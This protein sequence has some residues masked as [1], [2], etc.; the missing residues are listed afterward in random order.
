MATIKPTQSN[1]TAGELDPKTYARIDYEGYLKGC[2]KLRNFINIPQGGF[3]TRWGQVYVDTCTAT[4]YTQVQIDELIYND[5]AIYLLLWEPDTLTIYLENHVVQVLNNT[6]YLA[7]DVVNIYPTQ[8]TN[9]LVTVDA[10]HRPKLLVRSSNATNNITGFNATNNTLEITAAYPNSDV[11]YPVRFQNL[12]LADS[13]PTTSPQ[14]YR[15]REYF[16]RRTTGDNI[17]IY[18]TASDANDGI[19]FF[20]VTSAGTGTNSLMTQNTWTLSDY[21]IDIYPTIDITS[22]DASID[23][24]ALTFTN[25]AMTGT[26]ITIIASGNVFTADMVGGIYTWSGGVLRFNTY[27]SPTQMT[28]TVEQN[29]PSASTVLGIYVTVER[30]VWSDELGWP[31]ACSVYQNRVV[32]GGTYTFPNGL[33]LSAV[34]DYANFDDTDATLD[35]SAISFYPSD[36]TMSYIRAITSAKTLIVH[37]NTGSFSSAVGTDSPITP[38]NFTLTLQNKDGISD[39]IPVY[40]DNQIMYVDK[41][42]NNVKNMVFDLVEGIFTLDNISVASNHL[43]NRPFDMDSFGQPAQT[44]GNFVIF[45][46]QDGTLANLLTIRAQEI[47]AWSLINTKQ[48]YS[49]A[50]YRQVCCAINRCWFLVERPRVTAGA[51]FSILDA[52]LD[53]ENWVSQA[54]GMTV[55]T[56]TYVQITTGNAIAET[57]PQIISDDYYWSVPTNATSFQL[58]PSEEDAIARTNVIKIDGEVTPALDMFVIVQS[59]VTKLVIEEVD[60]DIALD[61]ATIFKNNGSS[62]IFNLNQLEGETVQ[63][64]ADGIFYPNIQV[65]NGFIAMPVDVENGYVGMGFTC[66]MQP[67]NINTPLGAYGNSFYSPKQVKSIY[68]QYYQTIGG[69]INTGAI[70]TPMMGTWELGTPYVPQDGTLLYSPMEGW[71]TQVLEILQDKPLPMTILGLGYVMEDG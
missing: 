37:T 14:I 48:T 44:D 6:G 30:P 54:H 27:N 22:V 55:G 52:F 62:N 71:D 25:S 9:R 1:F 12:V 50:Y 39:I 15:N 3:T 68:V 35:A 65:T 5:N 33:W 45:A 34:D 26:G 49:E 53:N 21:P 11:I 24:S 58:Y 41:S 56:P 13:L 42:G 16:A 57:T 7:E 18:A 40:T 51:T 70:Q 69:T 10:N 29:F 31:R 46:N 23:Y 59:F 20:S 60:F 32:F 19:N 63:V 2:K 4:D 64:V 38:R 61:N 66:Q 67:L 43:I 28:G 47:A 8:L 36:G 17:R